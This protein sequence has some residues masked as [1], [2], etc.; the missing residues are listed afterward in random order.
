MKNEELLVQVYEFNLNRIKELFE[1][2]S[3]RQRY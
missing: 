3:F 2:K 1:V